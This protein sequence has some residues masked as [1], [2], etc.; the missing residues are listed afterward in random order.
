MKKLLAFALVLCL[1]ACCALGLAED[2]LSVDVEPDY[3]GV[4][5]QINDDVPVTFLLPNDWTVT[6]DA[7]GSRIYQNAEE[8][9]TM[10]T[11]YQAVSLEDAIEMANS[12][13]G[14]ASNLIDINGYTYLCA[15]TQDEMQVV[16]IISV[17]DSHVLGVSF[18]VNE[19]S[20]NDYNQLAFMILGSAT[21]IE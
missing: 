13:E 8:T 21:P 11:Q 16:L 7:F 10:E 18:K 5:V 4:A 15:E 12:Q 19:G 14:I 9:L 6:E 17:D 3:E 20:V 2:R 1:C